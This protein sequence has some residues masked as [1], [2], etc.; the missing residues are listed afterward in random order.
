MAMTFQRWKSD[1]MA[2]AIAYG[3]GDGLGFDS[4]SQRNSDR[5]LAACASVIADKGQDWAI[6]DPA[7]FGNEVLS[8]LAGWLKLLSPLLKIFGF[9]NPYVAIAAWLLPVVI[10][11][12]SRNNAAVACGASEPLNWSK[13]AEQGYKQTI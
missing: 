8:K 9:S 2:D 13:I 1:V 6:G 10:E 3:S 4:K 7:A 12:L 11:W 5:Y